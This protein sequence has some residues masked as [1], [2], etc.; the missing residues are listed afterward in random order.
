MGRG[1]E[2][3]RRGWRKKRVKKKRKKKKKNK[4]QSY[5]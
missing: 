1:V 5:F 2:S 3:S 4:T